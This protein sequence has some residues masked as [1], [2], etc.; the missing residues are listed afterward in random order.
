MQWRLP[1][2]SDRFHFFLIFVNLSFLRAR[3]VV[4]PL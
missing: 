2:T 1:A 3:L 4:R